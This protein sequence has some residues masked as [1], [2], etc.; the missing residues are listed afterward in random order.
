MLDLSKHYTQLPSQL[1]SETCSTAAVVRVTGTGFVTLAMLEE[2]LRELEQESLATG[3]A[4][5]LMVDLREIVGYESSCVV[6]FGE[7]LESADR[8]GVQRVA[9]VAASSV[10][11]TATR[12]VAGRVDVQLATFDGKAAAQAWLTEDE[13]APATAASGRPTRTTTAKSPVSESSQRLPL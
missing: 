6:R 2:T 4:V 9:V 12:L 7:W 11:R 13:D 10:L 3:L 1:R 5:G 8:Y